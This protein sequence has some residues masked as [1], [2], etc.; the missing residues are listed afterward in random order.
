METHELALVKKYNLLNPKKVTVDIAWIV[1]SNKST[2]YEFKPH[3]KMLD[4]KGNL[5][6][7]DYYGL[8]SETGNSFIV[9]IT[10]PDEV[11]PLKDLFAKHYMYKSE[12]KIAKK[13]KI[14]LPSEIDLSIDTWGLVPKGVGLA[15]RKQFSCKQDLVSNLSGTV[16]SVGSKLGLTV[17]SSEIRSQDG[18]TKDFTDTLG[19][20]YQV[21]SDTYK[22][23]HIVADPKDFSKLRSIFEKYYTV[24]LQE[25]DFDST[26]VLTESEFQKL[27]SEGSILAKVSL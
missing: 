14:P 1:V 6:K 11:Y 5:K 20:H 10:E 4:S 19:I 21:V 12:A 16:S 13:Y 8:D 17:S 22:V 26:T 27:Q 9:Y 3:P 15:I 7:G 24:Q 25:L 2:V 18:F 23:A